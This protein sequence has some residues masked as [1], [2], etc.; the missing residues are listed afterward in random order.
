MSITTLIGT[1]D[2]RF[3]LNGISPI[4]KGDFKWRDALLVT[5]T[6]NS[7]NFYEVACSE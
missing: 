2:A 4:A 1:E 3:I 7:N 6:V 5:G